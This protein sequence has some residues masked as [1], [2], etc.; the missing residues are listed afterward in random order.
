M[1][2]RRKGY[3]WG[4]QGTGSNTGVKAISRVRV[5]AKVQTSLKLGI[6]TIRHIGWP[7]VCS[8]LC[9]ERIRKLVF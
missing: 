4:Q 2:E 8:M 9:A 3:D 6:A 1:R 7:F 5:K